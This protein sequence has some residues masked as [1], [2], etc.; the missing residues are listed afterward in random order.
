MSLQVVVVDDE[1]A[2][3]LLHTR[4][5][6]ADGRCKVVGVAGTGPDAVTAISDLEPDLVLLDI[7]LPGFSGLEVLRSIRALRLRQ[8][9]VIAVTAARDFASVR[10]ARLAGVRHYLVKP[11]SARDLHDRIADVLRESAGQPAASLEQGEIDALIRSGARTAALPKGLSV[12]TLESVRRAVAEAPWSTATQVG[13]AVGVSRVSSRRY[14]EHLVDSGVLERRL[15][16]ATSGRPS[17]RYGPAG[18]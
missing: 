18:T 9:E 11:F 12:E 14:L 6:E 2:V 10:D 1:P 7:H 15:D 5:L 13:D 8:P 4:F 17:A 16:Y 3:A